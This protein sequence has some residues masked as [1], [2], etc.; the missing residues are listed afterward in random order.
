MVIIV[1]SIGQRVIRLIAVLQSRVIFQQAFETKDPVY[2]VIRSL[3]L[4]KT[5][6]R[7]NRQV[8]VYGSDLGAWA[9]LP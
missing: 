9:N 1:T 3:K 7:G 6:E 2:F 8:K 4:E 5:Q